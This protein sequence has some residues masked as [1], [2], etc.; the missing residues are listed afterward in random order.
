MPF[1]NR[2]V[3]ADGVIIAGQTEHSA[4]YPLYRGRQMYAFDANTGEVLWNI[5]GNFEG[6]ALA[7]GILVSTD[8]YTG[9]TFAFGKGVSETAVSASP[10]TVTSS[11]AVLIEGSV[12]DQSPAQPGTPCVSEASMT[13]QM[14]Y[15]H[16][17]RPKP[18]N[19][20]GVQ[21]TLFAQDANGG[22]KTQIGVATTNDNGKF[23]FEWTPSS[24]GVYTITAEFAGRKPTGNPWTPPQSAS[25]PHRTNRRRNN[26]NTRIR[27][28]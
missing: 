6:K 22:A 25:H 2:P 15:L 1:Y 3:V 16:M 28:R 21:V 20:T 13:Q 4:T 9:T 26:R 19:N 8:M 18:T 7:D 27:N 12:L 24:A 11:N 17:S 14:E 5:A 23:A 10:K